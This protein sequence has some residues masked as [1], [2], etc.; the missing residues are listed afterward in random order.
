MT[1]APTP[2][3]D[4]AAFAVVDVVILLLGIPMAPEWRE[5]VAANVKTTAV[6]ARFVIDFPLPDD[7]EPA[8]VFRA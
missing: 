2:L 1:T 7:V 3:D 8:P 4:D 5:E 6:A